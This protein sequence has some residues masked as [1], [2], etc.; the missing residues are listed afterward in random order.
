[1]PRIAGSVLD[2][3]ERRERVAE[4][5]LDVRAEQDDRDRQREAQPELVAEHRDRMAGVPVVAG[6]VHVVI[7]GGR[8]GRRGHR[9]IVVVSHCVVPIL[10]GSIFTALVNVDELTLDSL[11]PAIAQDDPAGAVGH[12]LL[13]GP[14]AVDRRQRVAEWC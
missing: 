5:L 4:P 2:A 13:G 10:P 9:A 11:R 6:R 14:L 3:R 1:M 8:P 7:D 12:R